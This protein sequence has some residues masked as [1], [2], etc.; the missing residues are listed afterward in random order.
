MSSISTRATTKS[1]LWGG[2]RIFDTHPSFSTELKSPPYINISKVSVP[3]DTNCAQ[4]LCLA[5]GKMPSG[6]S[7]DVDWLYHRSLAISYSCTKLIGTYRYFKVSTL[8]KP[9]IVHREHM[10]RKY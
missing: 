2:E 1:N 9:Y 8:C 5:F 3:V 4:K 6:V 7:V 10:A